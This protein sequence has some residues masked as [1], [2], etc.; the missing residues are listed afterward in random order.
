ME[1]QR[2]PLFNPNGDIEVEKRRMVGGNTTNLNDFN[3][4]KYSWVSEWYRQAMNNFWVPEEIN[5]IIF[6]LPR[7]KHMTRF[8]LSLSSL[9]ACRQLTCQMSQIT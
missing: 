7:G 9:I 5:I 6:C 1:M 3:N 8:F 2:K 4:M